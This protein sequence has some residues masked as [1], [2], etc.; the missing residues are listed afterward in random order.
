MQSLTAAAQ[1]IDRRVKGILRGVDIDTLVPDDKKIVQHLRLACN[2][3][4]LDV[5]D[6]EYAQTRIEQQKWVKIAHHNINALERLI[7]GLD[8]IFGPVDVAELSAQLELLQSK[9]E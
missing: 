1:Q 5:R 4:K 2:E 6:Y 9:I 8:E 3:V 7:L